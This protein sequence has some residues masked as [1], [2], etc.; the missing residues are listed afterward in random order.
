MAVLSAAS[1]GVTN[2]TKNYIIPKI[3]IVDQNIKMIAQ[4]AVGPVLAGASTVILEKM[5]DGGDS[6]VISNFVSG[7]QNNTGAAGNFMVGAGAYLAADYT[8]SLWK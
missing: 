6:S 3:P 7:S 4:K 8:A 1:T 2:G 5:L